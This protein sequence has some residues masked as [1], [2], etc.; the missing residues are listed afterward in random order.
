[1]L[2]VSTP[3]SLDLGHLRTALWFHRQ[4]PLTLFVSLDASQN[5]AVR[6]LELRQSPGVR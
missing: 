2:T 1:M 4:S 3:R 5:Q 6:E